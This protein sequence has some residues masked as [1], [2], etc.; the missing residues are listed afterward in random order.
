MTL[1][2]IVTTDSVS[3]SV[4]NTKIVDPANTAISGLQIAQT[5]G[6][7][8]TAITLTGIE[9]TNGYQK[10]FVISASNINIKNNY[11]LGFMFF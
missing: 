9:L 3:A 10:T 7:T 5:A 2:Q 6:G 4:V 8:G 1:T 11:L